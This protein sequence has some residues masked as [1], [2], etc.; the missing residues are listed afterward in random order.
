MSTTRPISG[1]IR[2][3]TFRADRHGDKVTLPSAALVE[4]D[5]SDLMPGDSEEAE[6]AREDAAELWARTA[7]A[8]MIAAGLNDAQRETLSMFCVAVASYW[9]VTRELS[10]TGNLLR[11]RTGE[12]VKNPLH[13]V[14]TMYVN[15]VTTL[16]K[17]LGLSPAAAARI[18]R[19][20][21]DDDEYADSSAGSAEILRIVQGL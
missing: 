14:R 1:H 5:W 7:P 21:A 8:L 4:P 3:G 20:D 10:R 6:K 9:S 13:T 19:P 17:E 2:S 15:E 18:T 12:L 16:R 11:G